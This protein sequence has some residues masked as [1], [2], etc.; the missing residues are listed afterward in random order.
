MEAPSSLPHSSDKVLTVSIDEAGV[1]RAA[2]LGAITSDRVQQLK[3]DVAEAKLIVY[4]EFQKRGAKFKSLIDLTRFEGTYVPEAMSTVA[5]FM[6][7]NK[8]F[9]EKGAGYGGSAA[10]N[11]AGNIVATLA[12]RD[13][14]A[15]FE[16]EDEARAWLAESAQA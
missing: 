12:G 13:N 3:Q 6:R 2:L 7:S 14:L 4:G 10:S 16:S 15:F 9:I 5:D 1:L 8:S 11:T